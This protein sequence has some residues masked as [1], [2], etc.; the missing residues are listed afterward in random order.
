MKLEDIGFYT[1]SDK[2][3]EYVASAKKGAYNLSLHRCELILTNKCNF[4]CVY[5]RGIKSE[6]SKAL[7]LYAAKKIINIWAEGNLKNIRL[8]GGEPTIYPHLIELVKYIRSFKCFERIAL[9]TNGSANLSFYKE[10]ISLGVNDFSVSLD[11]CC[12]ST[13]DV[14][15]GTASVFDKIADNIAKLSELTY[16]TAGVVL[17]EKNI[18]ELRRIVEFADSLGVSDVRVIPSAQYDQK[19]DL[20]YDT[21]LPILKY[22]L[23]NLKSNRHVRGLRKTDCKKCH[24]VKDDMAVCGGYHFPCIIYMREQGSPIGKVSDYWTM[25][26]ER[27]EWFEKKNTHTDDICK[28][29]CLDVCIDHNNKVEEFKKAKPYEAE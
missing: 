2:R 27:F 6:Y 21:D 8:S 7:T 22:R 14:M 1:L 11:A 10:L 29:N 19:L 28:K 12:S 18:N 9:S 13:N 24:L 20:N 5:C 26:K 4:K 17:N 25:Q 16:V 23:N 3:A 15:T